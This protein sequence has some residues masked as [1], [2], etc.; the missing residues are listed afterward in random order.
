M[1][2]LTNCQQ[3]YPHNPRDIN[4]EEA[5]GLGVQLQTLKQKQ[6]TPIKL[7]QYQPKADYS[8]KSM[9]AQQLLQQQQ[10]SLSQ[11]NQLQ[12]PKAS[13]EATASQFAPGQQ[14]TQQ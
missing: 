14:P 8:N 4:Y 7:Q 3:N 5:G 13:Y 1:L 2:R 11:S 12:G 10:A 9:Q 6:H